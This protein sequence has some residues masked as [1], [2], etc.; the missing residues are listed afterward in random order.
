M[1]KKPKPQSGIDELWTQI[2][3]EA[4]VQLEG[5]S[6]HDAIEEALKHG[7]DPMH[8]QSF[9]LPDGWEDCSP[10]ECAIRLKDKPTIERLL[11]HGCSFDYNRPD[12]TW[13]G[14]PGPLEEMLEYEKD[15]EFG[16]WMLER[17]ATLEGQLAVDR[18]N[19]PL[20]TAAL[21]KD[22]AYSKWLLDRGGRVYLSRFDNM[23]HTPLILAAQH[24]SSAML[25]MFLEHGADPDLHD[26]DC[27]GFTPLDQAVMKGRVDNVRLLLEGGANPDIPTWMWVTARERAHDRKRSAPEIA[28]LFERVPIR[29][30]PHPRWE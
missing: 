25:R 14:L 4:I 26:E 17:G 3:G 7:A 18:I 22:F 11:R 1:E 20:H 10:F 29:R 15:L 27:A 24:E 8:L 2:L 12:T 21:M 16:D 23:W 5:K 9:E 19:T 6:K 13:G 30:I 28:K